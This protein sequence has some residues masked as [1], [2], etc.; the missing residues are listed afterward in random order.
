LRRELEFLMWEKVGIV[1]NEGDLQTALGDLGALQEQS[2]R[3]K[4]SRE[5]V[6]NLEWGE[7]INLVNLTL[8]GEMV[9]RSALY[10][11]ES[12]GAHYRSDL[13]EPDPQ[14]LKRIRMIS[15]GK[16]GMNLSALPIEF[17]RVIPPELSSSRPEKGEVYESKSQHL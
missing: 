2:R 13:P 11:K 14:W 8:V 16:G 7:A 3:V 12:R 6:F 9:A 15:D 1:R 5:P 10:R 17:T 4:T